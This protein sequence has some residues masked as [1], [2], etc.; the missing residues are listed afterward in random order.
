MGFFDWSAPLFAA[1]GNRWSAQRL[2]T[3]AGYLRPSVPEHGGRVLDLGGGT[4]VLSVRL[5][6]V[7]PAHYTVV[8]PT[9]AMTRYVPSRAD[10]DVVRAGAE[11]IPYPDGHFDAAITSDAFH[12]FPDQEAAVRELRRVVRP[13][14]RV[15]M[16]EFDRRLLPVALLERLVDWHGRLF[17]PGELCAYLAQRGIEG[18]C[19]PVSWLDFDFVGTVEPPSAAGGAS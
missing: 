2:A 18:T 13:G 17:S 19:E 8:D 15:V 12:H 9:A 16:L 7:L 5:A 6:T 11:A 1:F 14:G 3:V 4:G 10:V